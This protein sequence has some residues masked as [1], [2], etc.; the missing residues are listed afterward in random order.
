MSTPTGQSG[1]AYLPDANYTRT[2]TDTGGTYANA[3]LSGTTTIATGATVAGPLITG[4]EQFGASAGSAASY[5]KLIKQVTAFTDTT[6]KDVFTVSIPIPAATSSH[7]CTIR[8]TVLG[9]MG[10][11][12]T[13]GAGESASGSEYIMSV[14]RYVGTTAVIAT[15][16]QL[17]VANGKVAGADTLTATIAASAVTGGTSA[18]ETFTIQCTMTKGGGA[19]AAHQGVFIAELININGSGITIA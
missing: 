14:A 8:V 6:A 15:S 13:V 12:G 9:V 4:T 18:A 1:G 16:S 7:N 3:T 19:S 11:G 17:G 10:A 2:G 5:V